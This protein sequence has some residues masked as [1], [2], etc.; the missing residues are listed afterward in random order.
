[1]KKIIMVLC[2]VFLLGVGGNNSY[3]SEEQEIL[4]IEACE[5]PTDV[6]YFLQSIGKDI[7]IDVLRD[8]SCMSITGFSY[9]NIKIMEPYKVYCVKGEEFSKSEAYLFP[10]ISN[11]NVL[12]I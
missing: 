8:P 1:M 5:V 6:Y 10:V 7:I 9:D 4:G 2:I 3:A 12:L 11:G